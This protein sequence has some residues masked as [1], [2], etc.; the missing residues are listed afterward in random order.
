LP[1]LDG[2]HSRALVGDPNLDRGSLVLETGAGWIE[3]GPPVRSTA[4]V[5]NSTAS[6][7][8]F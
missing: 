1:L 4:F 5:P 8:R 7:P 6:G 3:D 2:A